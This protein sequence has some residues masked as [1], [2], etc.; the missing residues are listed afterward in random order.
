MIL[1]T[2]FLSEEFECHSPVCASRRCEGEVSALS[3]KFVFYRISGFHTNPQ[4][5]KAR[6]TFLVSFLYVCSN[7]GQLTRKNQRAAM[8]E[9]RGLES[10]ARSQQAQRSA[11]DVVFA[12][13]IRIVT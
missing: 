2:P 13:C 12:K 1:F 3:S 4:P 9:S 7:C 6:T 10:G 8:H 11:T 5:G